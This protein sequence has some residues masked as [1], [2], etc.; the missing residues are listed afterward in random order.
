MTAAGARAAGSGNRQQQRS[1]VTRQRLLD[2]AVDCLVER[3]WAGT[4][5]SLVAERAG[6]SRGAQLHHYRSRAELVVAAV[7]HL[8]E[9]RLAEVRAEAERLPPGRRRTESVLEMI[10]RV[11]TG[12]LFVAALE[13]WVAART[14]EALR[15]AVVP[16]ETRLGR[17][18]HRLTVELLG[19]DESRPDVRETVQGLLDLGRGLGLANLLTDDSTRRARVLRQWGRVLDEALAGV[20]P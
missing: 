1:R 12:P 15:A 4:T 20:R 8:A 5:T 13:L 17:E 6:V 19:L 7:E 11:F 16:L 3:G 9:A 18:T 2:A 14:D 10:A